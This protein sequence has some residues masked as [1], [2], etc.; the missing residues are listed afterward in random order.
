MERILVIIT[1]LFWI[2]L[3][4]NILDFPNIPGELTDKSKPK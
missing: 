4:P 1:A 2:G 3:G